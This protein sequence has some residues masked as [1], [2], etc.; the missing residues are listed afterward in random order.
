MPAYK[1]LIALKAI[2]DL[3]YVLLKQKRTPV[4]I[5]SYGYDKARLFESA[6]FRSG[7]GETSIE[8]L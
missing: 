4:S 2:S 6:K 5:S 8:F 1:V 3:L 7:I